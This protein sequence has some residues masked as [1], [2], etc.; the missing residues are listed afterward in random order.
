M[1]RALRTLLA[2]TA[3]CGTL[4][5]ALPAVAQTLPTG[6]RV[7][8]G[9]ATIAAPTGGRLDVTQ[10]SPKAVVDWQSFSVGS[11]GHVN[12]TQ[13]G[14][15]AI[16]LNRV[17]TPNLPSDIQGRI[18][19]NG[20]VWLVNPSGI[21]IGAGA[22]I[23][24]AGFLA[25]T[26]DI[27]NAD[28]MAGRHRFGTGTQPAGSVENEGTI[29]IAEAGLAALVAPHVANRGVIAARLGQV[30]LASGNAFTVDF[31]G[32]GLISFAV[33]APVTAP[34]IGR[35]GKVVPALVENAGQIH[36]DGG[37]V[38][39]TASAAK[40][41]VERAISMSGVVQ[42]RSVTRH[43]D[44]TI[45]LL[46]EGAGRV[47][48]SGTLDATAAEAAAKGGRITVA[49]ETVGLVGTATV[50]ASGPGGGEVRIGGDYL[51]GRATPARLADLGVIP[52]RKP[53]RNAEV[54]YVGP[55][56]NIRADAT[57]AGK[58]GQV[59]VWSDVTTRPHGMISARGGAQGGDGGFVETSGRKHLTATRAADVG[60][61]KGRGGTWL[62][63][64]ANITI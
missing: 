43:A 49:G 34:V 16:I 14:R 53:V 39:L 30:A 62:L 56:A 61:P 10:T 35:D 5:G 55:E 8:E 27:S 26:H 19:A 2:T 21:F 1:S 22:K 29:T 4:S 57:V 18:S 54:V 3:L 6:G 46:G 17:A 50:D 44:G 13:P 9:Q 59:V 15:D 24:V 60:A 63:D 32:D 31:A 51:G 37:R 11:S 36:A 58:G 47:E 52:A 25:T 42:A 38:L 33:T 64:P 23:D 28:F 12:F 7:V 45:E 41:I 40:G 48:V 20:Q